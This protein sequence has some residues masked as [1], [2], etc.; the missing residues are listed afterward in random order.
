MNQHPRVIELTPTNSMLRPLRDLVPRVSACAQRA[1]VFRAATGRRSDRRGCNAATTRPPM[2]M[3]DKGSCPGRRNHFGHRTPNAPA[4]PLH[5]WPGLRRSAPLLPPFLGSA[6]GAPRLHAAPT[7]SAIRRPRGRPGR[8]QGTRVGSAQPAS[9]STLAMDRV[10]T[11]ATDVRGTSPVCPSEP[12][13]PPTN[14]CASAQPGAFPLPEYAH[15]HS[16]AALP[17]TS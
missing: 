7:T 11:S 17:Q 9:K 8:R 3:R 15:M 1:C 4:W 6:R 14:A 10:P 13:A 16:R 2:T 12:R 5:R